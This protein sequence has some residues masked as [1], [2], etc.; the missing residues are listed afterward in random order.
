MSKKNVLMNNKFNEL[1]DVKKMEVLGIDESIFSSHRFKGVDKSVVIND[2][3]N[4]KTN[5]EKRALLTV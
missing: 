1:E 3:W 2:L 4:G 5:A